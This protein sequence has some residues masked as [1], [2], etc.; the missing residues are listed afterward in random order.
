MN[1]CCLKYKTSEHRAPSARTLSVWR[2][3]SRPVYERTMYVSLTVIQLDDGQRVRYRVPVGVCTVKNENLG[4]CVRK[5]SSLIT[6][7]PAMPKSDLLF[8]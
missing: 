7:T 8:V 1:G 4:F 2:P 6:M 5:A 3:A